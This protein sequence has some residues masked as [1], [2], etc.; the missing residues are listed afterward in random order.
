MKH[1][2]RLVF[3]FAFAGSAFAGD[4]VI[5]KQKHSDAGM[6]QP[7]K[8]TTEVTWIGQGHMRIEDATAITIVRA[9]LKKMYM[10]DPAA[11]T[12]TTVDL[13]FDMKKYMPPEMA[14]HMDQMFASSKATL[15]PT[16]ETKKVKDWNATK[17]T[18]AVTLPMGGSVTQEMWVTKDVGGD[19]S[20][21]Q[22]MFSAQNALGP[23]AASMAA[24]LKKLDGLPLLTETTTVMMGATMKSS[25][26]VTSIEEKDAP[27]GHYDV[28]SGYTEKPFDPMAGM[29]MGGPGGRPRKN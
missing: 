26:S 23:F 10:L 9:D 1:L 28:P 7:A 2:L 27:A 18:L 8:D 22:E 19:R 16:T 24:E 11:K 21:W 4:T 14:A 17:Y 13:P 3:A 20:G 25:E 5:T 12:C 15:T 29:G 6:G